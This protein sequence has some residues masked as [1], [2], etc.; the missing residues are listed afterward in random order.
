MSSFSNPRQLMAWLGRV[1]NEHSSGSTV[2][3]RAS[4]RPAM[5]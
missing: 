1:P 3:R 2:R 5:P 4:P